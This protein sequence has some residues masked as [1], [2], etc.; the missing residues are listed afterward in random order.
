M[1]C[2]LE[3]ACCDHRLFFHRERLVSAQ[4]IEIELVFVGRAP[5][6]GLRG[7]FA[8][9]RGR[10]IRRTPAFGV[11]LNRAI[12][13]FGSLHFVKIET[14]IDWSSIAPQLDP[15]LSLLPKAVGILSVNANA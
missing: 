2:P 5:A 9:F 8:Q 6:R 1:A 7:F 13:R 12:N 4:Y 11:E 15:E 3:A 10:L 14:K